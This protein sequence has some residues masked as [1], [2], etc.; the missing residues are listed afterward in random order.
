MRILLLATVLALAPLATSAQEPAKASA[1]SARTRCF[2]I[3][4]IITVTGKYLPI[5]GA[6]FSLYQ[7]RAKGLCVHYPKRTSRMPLTD[8][9]V[10]VT[11]GAI[12]KVKLPPNLY[13]EVTGTLTDLYPQVS[14]VGFKVMSVR[15]VDVEVKAEIAEWTRQC[16]RWQDGQLSIISKRLHGGN[17]ERI[18]D[19]LDRKCGV[20]GVDAELPHEEIGPIWRRSP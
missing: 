14:P 1:A 18:T 16:T 11:G 8:L 17:T 5:I 10:N 13:L 2:N 4:D 20:A 7:P 6:N 3:G 15:D 9:D 12:G 19:A